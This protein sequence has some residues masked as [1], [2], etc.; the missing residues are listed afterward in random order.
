MFIYQQGV[1]HFKVGEW[2][3][4]LFPFKRSLRSLRML[5]G[6]KAYSILK[7]PIRNPKELVKTRFLGVLS[8]LAEITSLSLP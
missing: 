4:T 1:V 6:L 3:C 5:T 7:D 2:E 8:S